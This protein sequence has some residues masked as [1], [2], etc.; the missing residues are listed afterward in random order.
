MAPNIFFHEVSW[1]GGVLFQLL[2]SLETERSLVAIHPNP[3]FRVVPLGVN[4]I[5]LGVLGDLP[6]QLDK[7]IAYEIAESR[8][9]TIAA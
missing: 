8:M 9:H 7:V 1:P 6:W 5:L 3:G 4:K 2:C